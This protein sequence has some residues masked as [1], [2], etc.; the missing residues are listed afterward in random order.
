MPAHDKDGIILD[1]L[2][3]DGSHV[4]VVGFQDKPQLRISVKPENLRNWVSERTHEQWERDQVQMKKDEEQRIRDEQRKPKK[5]SSSR[6]GVQAGVKGKGRKRKRAPS[7]IEPPPARRASMLGNTPILP[8]PSGPS[9]RRKPAEEEPVFASPKASQKSQGPS[10]STPVKG[11]GYLDTDE[12]EEMDDGAA[13][14]LQLKGGLSRSRSTTGTSRPSSR[15]YSHVDD[16]SAVA[17]ITSRAARQTYE[18][19]DAR[20]KKGNT[21]TIAKKYSNLKKPSSKFS[22]RAGMFSPPN[23][24]G[25]NYQAGSPSK[26]YKSLHTNATSPK[27]AASLAREYG[28]DDEEDAV[29][30]VV[31]LSEEDDSDEA[32]YDV[33]EILDDEVRKGADGKRRLHYLIKWVGSWD[34]TW[35]PAIH[36]GQ[37]SINEYN[38]MKE[39]KTS[40][41]KSIDMRTC[42]ED[43]SESDRSGNE[44][45]VT[46]RKGKGKAVE[47]PTRGQVIDDDSAD[48]D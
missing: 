27:N 36:V 47:T 8:P 25:K 5:R 31:V 21:E 30:L 34:N 43:A 3:L 7:L 24:H 26:P 44:M 9:R 48:S 45:F 20:S 14:A 35:E 17:S 42:V 4:Y 29:D 16:N 11:L 22:P 13:L 39:R 12:D 2:Q 19:L 32:E 37:E 15:D 1:T 10:L 23:V 38:K 6:E 33:E 40:H 46:D 28:V 18:D 41:G